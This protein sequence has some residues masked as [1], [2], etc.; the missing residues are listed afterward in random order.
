MT[1]QKIQNKA[2]LPPVYFVVTFWGE[3]FI[4]NFL[5]ITASSLLA[6][7]NIPGMLDR[8]NARIVICTDIASKTSLS[9]R[10]LFKQLEEVITVEFLLFDVREVSEIHKYL[11]MSRNHSRLLRRAAEDRAVAVYLA[12]DTLVPDGSVLKIQEY[13]AQGA[14]TA[15]A[16][17]VRFGQ[18]GIL[19]R[20]KRD[21]HYDKAGRLSIS[22]RKLVEIALDNLHPETK[23]GNFDSNN[24]GALHRD[25]NMQD[26]VTCCYFPVP[27]RKAVVLFTHNWAAT[28]LNFAILDN[29]DS[30]A[31][32][33][34][35]I[36]GD[37][38]R[39]TFGKY[40]I[41]KEVLI[42]DDSDDLFWVGLTPEEE[43]VPASDVHWWKAEEPWATSS[44]AYIINRTYLDSF[45]DDFR[46]KIY[47]NP[48]LWHA[49][50]ID[51][52]VD[53]CKAKSVQI[54][55]DC[56]RFDFRLPTGVLGVLYFLPTY[57]RYSFLGRL[58]TVAWYLLYLTPRRLY[59]EYMRY[60]KNQH[61]YQVTSFR[62][63]PIY[64]WRGVGPLVQRQ[65]LRIGYV[66]LALAGS[67]VHREA[68]KYRMLSSIKTVVRKVTG[69]DTTFRLW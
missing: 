47:R 5:N 6:P 68:M 36:D 34:W 8:N 64:R 49:T 63:A 65:L 15:L 54:I 46:R 31:L 29:F 3:S 4:N 67:S 21:G 30:E 19:N 22:K 23:A 55:R 69:E 43:M 11:L 14:V 18:H 50:E 59:F 26:F 39:A 24:F 40:D 12:P 9:E 52:A 17:A 27:D 51:S 20:L 41:G 56:T 60:P 37:F 10:D 33:K 48:T 16:A 62:L 53:T 28:F 2:E 35:A 57:R 32:E 1:S 61:R 45:T 13:V 44:K 25:H 58:R 7:G 66:S 38:L 42:A